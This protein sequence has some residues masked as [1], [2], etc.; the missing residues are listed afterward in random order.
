MAAW[1]AA[2]YSSAESDGVGQKAREL[3]SGIQKGDDKLLAILEF[4]QDDIRYLG[5]ETGVNS[6]QPHAPEE[7]LA[8]RFGD[9][10]DK[11]ALFCA[12]ARE[13]GF[14]AWPVLVSTWRREMVKADAPSPL[15]FNHVI[16]AVEREG[17]LL[18]LD[19]TSAKQ[20]GPLSQ[21]GLGDFGW[22]LVLRPE[23]RDLQEL[24]APR[25][26][27]ITVLE[28]FLVQD[29]SGPASVEVRYFFHGDSADYFRGRVAAQ[30]ADDLRKDFPEILN[31]Q[32]QEIT[33]ISEPS[34]SDDH[35]ANMIEF[36]MFFVVP[37]FLTL[38][39][40]KYAIDLYPSLILEQVRDPE[41]VSARAYP[42][43]FEHPV[44]YSQTQTVILPEEWNIPHSEN[45]V[46]D[47]SFRLVTAISSGGKKI[48]ISSSFKSLSDR[49][50]P[51]NWSRFL[52]HLKDSRNAIDWHLW[53]NEQPAKS[54]VVEAPPA[55]N[56][57][58]DTELAVELGVFMAMLAIFF[59]T[60]LSMGGDY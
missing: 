18:F 14:Q 31:D 42:M 44:T 10:K 34:I 55:D 5:M 22:G 27:Y 40:G 1:G 12:L 46:E 36:R 15:S 53:K 58:S 52:T 29:M 56:P 13:A 33:M 2:L 17:K 11:A 32:F 23:T 43:Y 45:I 6:H 50:E 16:A 20:G 30:S 60:A 26:S 8:N 9:C 51:A 49:V 41:T 24:P 37:R 7:A 35:A 47:P 19:P 28:D 57:V 38:N 39:G 3:V 25:E 54:P 21:R 4:V 59:L 48:R